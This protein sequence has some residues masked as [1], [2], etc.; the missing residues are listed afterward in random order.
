VTVAHVPVWHWLGD[1]AIDEAGVLWSW[2]DRPGRAGWLYH[3]PHNDYDV[4]PALAADAVALVDLWRDAH[5][6]LLAAAAGL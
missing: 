2:L 6:C 5:G 3:G 1:L 4:P